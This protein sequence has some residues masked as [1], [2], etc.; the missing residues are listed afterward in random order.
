MEYAVKDG[1]TGILL[2]AGS[3]RRF[4]ADK[5][6]TP[7]GGIP[8]LT[9]AARLLLDAGFVKP[10]VVLGPRAVEH[11]ARL[12]DL[13]VRIVEN[14]AADSGMAS[15]L[16]M[17]L[18]AAQYPDA[19]DA[20][21]YPDALD[22]AQYPD[23]TDAAG[24]CDA[25]VVTVCDQPAVTAAHLRALVAAWREAGASIVASSYAGTRGVPALFAASHFAE[26]R[27]LRGD[28]GAGPLLARH[29]AMVHVIPL[30]GG[31][32]D[33]DTPADL[34]HLTDDDFRS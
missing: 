2:A 14:P 12:S 16:V 7:I 30:P 4:G 20:A 18:D 32:I 21:Q 33:I 6:S 13:P 28:R 27:Q 3:S 15:S 23:A 34:D 25:V 22:A 26:L 19:L 10:I 9:R 8:M 31:E 29:A 11:R 5:Q 24:G 1:I 17:A